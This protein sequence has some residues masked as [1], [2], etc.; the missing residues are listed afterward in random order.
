MEQLKVSTAFKLSLGSIRQRLLGI[1]PEEASFV[2]R[3]FSPGHARERLEQIGVMFLRGYQVALEETDPLGLTARLNQ[4]DSELRGFAFEGAAMALALLD[5]MTP[6]KKDRWLYFMQS[7]GEKH[8]YMSYVGVG[9]ALARLQRWRG[10][11]PQLTDP[12]LRWL[13]MDGYGFHEGYFHWP[14]FIRSR[15]LPER[16][17]GYSRRVFDQGLGRSLWFVNGADVERIAAT[18]AAFPVT[19]RADLWSGVGLACAYAGGVNQAALSSMR[20]A[21]APYQSQLAQGASFAAKTRQR[22]GNLTEHTEMACRILCGI[23]A[24]EAA[25]V[26]DHAQKNLPEDRELPAYEIWRQRIQARFSS[27]VAG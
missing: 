13:A 4:L 22:A 5:L 12:L 18:V 27:E 24:A 16:L 6:W 11:H 23:S 2:R 26:T 21:A 3:G 10:G 14:K 9:W 7:G 15:A 8:I 17:S 25:E 1:A 20:V 19:R